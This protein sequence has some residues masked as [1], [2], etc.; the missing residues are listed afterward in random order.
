MEH[1]TEHVNAHWYWDDNDERQYSGSYDVESCGICKEEMP[2]DRIA[3]HI[4]DDCFRK[5]VTVDNCI[6]V[7]ADEDYLFHSRSKY[8]AF[9][10]YIIDKEE[11]IEVLEEFFRDAYEKEKAF[12]HSWT[13]DDMVEWA[14]ADA[15]TF[16]ELVTD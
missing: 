16:V 13:Y 15:D 1:F 8:N 2:E 14:R 6:K 10:E 11:I 5:L 7:G 4:C 12:G 9:L 3:T